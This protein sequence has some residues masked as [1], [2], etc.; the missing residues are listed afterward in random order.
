MYHIVVMF[1][2]EVVD[3]EPQMESITEDVIVECKCP[4]KA[5][6]VLLVNPVCKIFYYLHATS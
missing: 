3:P 4:S 6:V 5:L 2:A 1:F